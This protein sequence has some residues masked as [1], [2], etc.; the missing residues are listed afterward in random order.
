MDM[1]IIF[2]FSKIDFFDGIDQVYNPQ[3]WRCSYLQIRMTG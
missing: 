3:L 2:G 1:M